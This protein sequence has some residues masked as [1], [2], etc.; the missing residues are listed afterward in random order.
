MSEFGKAGFGEVFSESPALVKLT[1]YLVSSGV[2]PFTFLYN[3]PVKEVFEERSMN[4]CEFESE[5]SEDCP[6]E[7]PVLSVLAIADELS[8]GSLISEILPSTESAF[9]MA[10][11]ASL[12]STDESS[13]MTVCRKS[14]TK[15]LGKHLYSAHCW[16]SFSGTC[17]SC[18]CS[19]GFPGSCSCSVCE[20]CAV[21]TKEER[22]DG[23]PP[24]NPALYHTMEEWW[25]TL[26]C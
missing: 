22:P 8:A 3:V 7:N 18:T 6:S 11:D 24:D 25:D 13:R 17:P 20:N 4:V 12:L 14:V 26:I 16:V 5:V 2:D 21:K 23:W 10:L 19:W 1:I 9:V 15:V